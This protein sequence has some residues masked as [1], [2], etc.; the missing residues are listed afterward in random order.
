MDLLLKMGFPQEA[1]KRA[2]FYTLNQ[3]LESA[4]RWLM[5]HITD[6]NYA[7]PFVPTRQDFSNG[8]YKLILK[9]FN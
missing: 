9:F 2:L 8:S 6:Q 7:D 5:D 4:T 3:G 1:I